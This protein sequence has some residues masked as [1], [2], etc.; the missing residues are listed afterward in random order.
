MFMYSRFFAQHYIIILVEYVCNEAAI[1]T[2]R[3]IG[4]K[5]RN[6]TTRESYDD[7]RGTV[8]ESFDF[9]SEYKALKLLSD[10]SNLIPTIYHCCV[11]SCIA[12]TGKYANLDIC[13]FCREPRYFDNIKQ[14]PCY[15]FIYIPLIPQLKAI[16]SN[17][18]Y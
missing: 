3:I 14:M 5:I 15:N 8:A 10:L 4:W 13:P 1:N 18:A 11:N 9:D 17:P 16:F 6:H 12:F 2:L 7:L